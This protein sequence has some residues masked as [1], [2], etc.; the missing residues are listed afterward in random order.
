MALGAAFWVLVLGAAVIPPLGAVGCCWCWCCA[1]LVLAVGANLLLLVVDSS[2]AASIGYQGLQEISIRVI[3]EPPH[4]AQH[5]G[6]VPPL[7]PGLSPWAGLMCRWT[8]ARSLTACCPARKWTCGM[9]WGMR[10]RWAQRWRCGCTASAT[11]A[12]TASPSRCVPQAASLGL[13]ASL[14]F[15]AATGAL[16]CLLVRACWSPAVPHARCELPCPSL[17]AAR[18]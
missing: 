14:R 17:A 12:C 16:A 9:N 1:L 11:P 8:L 4:P 5:L 15:S 6:A 18:Q 2:S 13:S 7:T 3:R 10:W